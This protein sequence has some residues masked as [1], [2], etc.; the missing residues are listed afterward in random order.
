MRKYSNYAEAEHDLI[1]KITLDPDFVNSDT[2]ECVGL[3][4]ILTDPCNNKNA[5]ANYEYAEEFFQ[6]IL[7][8]STSLS[9][10]I[11][12]LNPFAKQ[13]VDST[14]LPESYSSS[15]GAKIKQQLDIVL[16]EL[17]SNKE[18]RRAY[19]NVLYPEDKIILGVETTHE[20]PCTIGFQFLIRDNKLHMS[21]QMRSNNVVKVMPYDVYNFT[22]LQQ[23]V[24]QKLGLELGNYYHYIVSAHIF[25]KNLI[26]S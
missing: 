22:R 7:S 4:F 1:H 25:N 20:F 13:F 15:Y 6:W 18:S 5:T 3:G 11:K 24:G 8:G 17:G 10:R 14:N 19:V 23:Y 2:Y 16:H 9:Q 21:V 26:V 12:E